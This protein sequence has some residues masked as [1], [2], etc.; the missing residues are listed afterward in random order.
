MVWEGGGLGNCLASSPHWQFRSRHLKAELMSSDTDDI[1]AIKRPNLSSK[2]GEEF[3]WQRVM[4]PPISH[5]N[6]DS[7]ML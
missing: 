4:F 7:Q 2:E 5:E 1:T 3:H 6:N